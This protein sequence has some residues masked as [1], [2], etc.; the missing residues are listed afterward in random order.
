[1]SAASGEPSAVVPQL[2]KPPPWR[3][4]ADAPEDRGD[5]GGLTQE[6]FADEDRLRRRLKKKPPASGDPSANIADIEKV[7]VVFKDG[8]GYDSAKLIESVRGSVGWR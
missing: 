8:V 1:M 5:R 7:E 4:R 2:E 3:A 6:D